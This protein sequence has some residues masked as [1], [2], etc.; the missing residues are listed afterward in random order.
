MAQNERA[1]HEGQSSRDKVPTFILI[2][3]LRLI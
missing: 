1:C 2:A 3:V